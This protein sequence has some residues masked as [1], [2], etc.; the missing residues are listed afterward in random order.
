MAYKLTALIWRGKWIEVEEPM[1]VYQPTGNQELDELVLQ[2]NEAL[3]QMRQ[4]KDRI[5]DKKISAQI[6]QLEGLSKN[7]FGHV[8]KNPGKVPQIRKFMNYYLPTTLKL[9]NS[10]AEVS[11]QGVRGKNI[12]ATMKRIESIMDTVVVA[13]EKQLDGLF[14]SDALDIS[15]DITVLEGML[16][17]E[18]LTGQQMG[19]VRQNGK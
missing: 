15:T 13:F 10:Y 6:D 1:P 14:S 17:R 9:L 4:L 18:G 11:A 3:R 5:R 19:A 16:Q 8:A 7:I 12:T 2:G